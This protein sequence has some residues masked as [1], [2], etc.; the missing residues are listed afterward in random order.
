MSIRSLFN[1]NVR[2]ILLV[3]SLCKKFKIKI[4]I[5]KKKK[6]KKIITITTNNRINRIRETNTK[7]TLSI[8]KN[9]IA[10]K[11]RLDFVIFQ[12][13]IKES[14]RILKKNNFW[15]KEIL[16]NASL[17]EI[18]FEIIIYKVRVASISKNIKKNDAKTFIKVNNCIYSKVTINNIK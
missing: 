6:I 14:K 9:I 16:S 15:T 12:L 17:R 7:A 18:N 8:Y 4:Y 1:K 2:R 5:K 11:R 13:K 10:I 3:Q